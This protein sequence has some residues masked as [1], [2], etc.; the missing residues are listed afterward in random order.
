MFH[1]KHNN[2]DNIIQVHICVHTYTYN[3]LPN[4]YVILVWYVIQNWYAIYDISSEQVNDR[5]D[6][7]SGW[8]ADEKPFCIR[9]FF[10]LLYR[11]KNIFLS[12]DLLRGCIPGCSGALLN[13]IFNYILIA[14]CHKMWY[15]WL[16]P[17]EQ[18]NKEK[19]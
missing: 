14:N 7:R 2:K 9:V 6:R 3:S 11:R 13:F 18:R 16:V 4:R 19:N 12:D 10:Y 1:V 17:K 5:D 8:Q 15:T